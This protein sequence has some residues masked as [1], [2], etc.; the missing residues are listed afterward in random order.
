MNPKAILDQHEIIPKKALGQNFL[1]D[2]NALEKIVAVAGLMPDDTVLEVGPGTG[3]LTERLARAAR[4]VIAVEIDERLRGPLEALQ[5]AHPNLTVIFADILKVDVLSAVGPGDFV[6]VANVPYYISS[7]IL[8]HLLEAPRRP[9]RLVLTVQYELA[10]RIVAPPGDLSL[11]AVSV[12]YYGRAQIAGRLPPAVFWPRPDVDSAVL[13]I[14]THAAPP[15]DVPDDATFFRV[16]RAGFSQKRKQL[17]NAL[18]G[19]LGISATAAGALLTS[20]GID[21][22][23]RAE[24]LTLAEWAALA[25]AYKAG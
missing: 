17:K 18:G 1:H 12:A 19:G 14:D 3:A 16:A 15:V 10:E 13:R 4:R 11:L 24:T 5:A 20:A 8:R 25:R 2:P 22:T 7:A 9:R 23:R 21:P 6:V